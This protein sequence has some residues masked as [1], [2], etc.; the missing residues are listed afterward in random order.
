MSGFPL[1]YV[2]ICILPYTWGNVCVYMCW[3]HVRNTHIHSPTHRLTRFWRKCYNSIGNSVS[4]LAPPSCSCSFVPLTGRAQL[5][6]RTSCRGP[7]HADE[8]RELH[9]RQ[10]EIV[11]WVST[12]SYFLSSQKAFKIHNQHRQNGFRLTTS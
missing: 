2:G 9:H 12:Y 6:W 5:E 3:G 10:K 8:P 11:W 4:V 1:L 7:L